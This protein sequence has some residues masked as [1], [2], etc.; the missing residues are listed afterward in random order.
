[1]T[2]DQIRAAVA[3]LDSTSWSDQD[4]IWN[5]LRPCGEAVVPYLREAYPTFRKW[6]GRVSLVYHS[7]RFARV[8]EDAFQ[9]GLA[10]LADRATLVRYRACS[11]LAFPCATMRLN[12][13]SAC[14]TIPMRKPSPTPRP[15]STPFATA[16]ITF[17]STAATVGGAFGASIPA[18]GIDGRQ[19][20]IP[21]VLLASRAA[22]GV[23][24]LRP[25]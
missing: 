8:S 22:I 1:V 21:A 18:I 2:P 20:A 6:Q 7:I 4:E 24:A 19:S 25:K 15:R 12:R 11:L 10:A 5:G 16:I 23:G 13:S 3:R 17:S 14:S 9:L